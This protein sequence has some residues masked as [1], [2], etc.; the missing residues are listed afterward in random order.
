MHAEIEALPEA[1]TQVVWAASVRYF[2]LPAGSMARCRA[3]AEVATELAAA[4]FGYH[5]R[6]F[7]PDD[8]VA[9]LHWRRRIG[10]EGG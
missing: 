5:G 10:E 3:A 9:V 7:G 8:V 2:G 6:P 1:A 4:G